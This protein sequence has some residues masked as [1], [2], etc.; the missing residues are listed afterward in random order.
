M[1]EN[2]HP[3]SNSEVIEALKAATRQVVHPVKGI[4]SNGVQPAENFGSPVVVTSPVA[5]TARGE[6]KQ[7]SQSTLVSENFAEEF[8]KKLAS[9]EQEKAEVD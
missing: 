2:D 7:K 1:V 6:L 4:A 5:H 3:Q 8:V 9:I